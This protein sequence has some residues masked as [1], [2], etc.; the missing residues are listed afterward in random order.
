MPDLLKRHLPGSLET[1]HARLVFLGLAAS[2]AASLL[3]IAV[4]QIL[5]VFALVGAVAF[6]KPRPSRF[7]HLRPMLFALALFLAWTVLAALASSD[8]RLGLK[9]VKKFFLFLI[10]LLV[11]L[12]ARGAGKIA[13]IYRAVFAAAVASSALGLLQ[14]I[15][16]PE[17]DLLHRISGL[18]SQW[19]TYSGLLMLALVALAAYCAC[20]DWRRHWWAVPAGTIMFAAIYLSQTRS[21]MLGV[22]AGVFVVLMLRRPRATVLLL[23]LVPAAYFLSPPRIQQRFRAGWHAGDPNTRNRI[24]LVETSLRLIGDNPWFGVGPK[25]V[26]REAPRYRG[27]GDY[28]GWMYQHMHNNMLQ[29]AAERGIPGLL[30]WLWFMVRLAWDAWRVFALSR[31]DSASQEALMAATAALGCWVALVAS[32]FF[33]YNFGDSEILTLFLFIMAAPYVFLGRG[34]EGVAAGGEVVAQKPA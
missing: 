5:L 25:N 4:S 8:V 33:E 24:E 9:I 2:V 13:W 14:F 12:A 16:N 6:L 7:S 20:C 27:S 28:P 21:A 22:I 29:L 18:M 26:A 1:T 19:M 34:T 23:I 15:R 17:R 3:S 10:L 30:L 11:P 31:R 32:G